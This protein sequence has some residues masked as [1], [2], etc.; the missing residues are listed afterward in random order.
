MAMAFSVNIFQSFACDEAWN[1]WPFPKKIGALRAE[2]GIRCGR[3][4]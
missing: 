3:S 1:Q 4:R 2:H